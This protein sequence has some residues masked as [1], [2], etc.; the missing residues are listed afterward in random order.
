MP[1]MIKPTWLIV[2]GAVATA[3]A[4]AQQVSTEVANRPTADD[5]VLET[6]VVTA[7]KREEPL[8]EIPMSVTALGGERL[9]EVQ[10]REFSDYAA[11]VPGLSLS[12]AQ[13]GFTR[14]TLRG[15]NAGG[16]GST[17]A[18]YFD[19]SPFGSSNALLNGAVNTGDF[20]T[21][22]MQRIEVLRG[23]QGTLYG[24]NSEGGLLKF[25]TNAPEL[26]KFSVGGELAW[27]SI[28]H[29]GSDADVHGLL[30]MPLGDKAAFRVSGFYQGVPGYIDDPASGAKNVNEGHKYGGRASFLLEPSSDFSMR[31]T[32]AAQTSK[33]DGTNAEDIDPVTLQPV[34]GE[35]T[36]ERVLAEPSEFKY[37]NYAMDL[38]W[39]LGSFKLVSITSYSKLDTDQI[40]DATPTV[41]GLF[42]GLLFGG[43]PGVPLIATTSLK[44]FTEE[45]RLTSPSTEHFDW[46]VGGY[47]THEDG[48][49]DQTINAV[50][51]PGG[52]TVGNLAVLTIDST[53]KEIAGFADFTYHFNEQFQVELGGRWS[54][55]DQDSTQDTVYNPGFGIAPDL[56]NGNSSDSVWTYSLAPSWHFSRDTMAYARLATGY[57]PGGPN[58][59][60]P[61]PAASVPTQY[62]SDKTTNIELGVRT[63]QLDG[64]LSLDVA[65]FHV[66]WTDIQLLANI[67]GININTNGGTAKSQGVEWTFGY[68]PVRG[69][70]F[71][72]NGAYTDAKLTSP[73]P[74]LNANDGDPL[75]YAPKWTT[76]LDGQYQWNAFA[77]Y[78]GFAGATWSYVDARSSDFFSSAANPPGQL[79]LPSYN[80]WA[81]RFGFENAHYR[82][83]IY[84]KNLSDA[85]GITNYGA[86]AAGAPYSTVTVIQPRTYGIAVS[87]MF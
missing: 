5:S 34:H 23:P 86:T 72:W 14:L 25:V 13:P 49:L 28:S 17:V 21:Y 54:K 75:P 43:N 15:Q 46:Q 57:R 18:V 64:R 83:S 41:F 9:D 1:S 81:A 12:S 26:G 30:N 60:P 77:D 4:A 52:A 20:D 66:D 67:G 62:Q 42:A 45:V 44:K 78:K 31:L 48:A 55:N 53:Y 6:I 84:G 38:D 32:A 70:T 59:L 76:N 19:E 10:A 50:A 85:R 8:K 56:R 65:A 35:L 33:Y 7:Q 58:A 24:A 63:T 68:V 87:A 39:N 79:E 36:Q 29:G 16:V 82:F 3:T 61:N 40:T 11:M 22:D 80:T 27:D 71:Q 69:L 51:I 37:Q 2:L 74:I 73:V 47:Y